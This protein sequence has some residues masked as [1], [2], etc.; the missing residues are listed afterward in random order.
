[1]ENF[2]LTVVA[3]EALILVDDV[4]MAV[5]PGEEGDFGVLINHAAIITPLRPG[6]LQT[7]VKSEV[8][9]SLFISGGFASVNERGCTILA[10]ECIFVHALN[11]EKLEREL[12]DITEDIDMSR[13]EEERLSYAFTCRMIQAK[14]DVLERMLT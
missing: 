13:N 14:L 7:F 6:L 3:P 9:D 10:E 1:M 2:T 5:I 8:K 11:K 4:T 12:K